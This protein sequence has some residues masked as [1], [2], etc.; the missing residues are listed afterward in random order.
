MV[1]Q[2]LCVRKSKRIKNEDSKSTDG[3]K[4]KPLRRNFKNHEKIHRRG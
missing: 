4:A 2:Y 1:M 3:E